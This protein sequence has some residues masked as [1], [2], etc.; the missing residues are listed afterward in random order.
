MN[1]VSKTGLPNERIREDIE[2]A[3]SGLVKERQLRNV[4]LL[5]L[6]RHY[7]LDPNVNS[8]DNDNDVDSAMIAELDD[9][10]RAE[11]E[12]EGERQR[13]YSEL[14]AQ[15]KS[16]AE[17]TMSVYIRNLCLAARDENKRLSNEGI[18]QKVLRSVTKSDL[19]FY[20]K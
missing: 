2:I 14:L 6:K 5:E 19:H 12:E 18:Q 1:K 15:V 16:I 20:C 13:T 10:R 7:T 9:N 3:L 17:K 11:G 8:N 4:L